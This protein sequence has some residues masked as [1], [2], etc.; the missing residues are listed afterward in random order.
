M[1]PLWEQR[2]NGG[3]AANCTESGSRRSSLQ[4]GSVMYKRNKSEVELNKL[5]SLEAL[6]LPVMFSR[7]TLASASFL[8]V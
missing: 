4:N 8:L 7:F 5:S 3:R 2:N 1:K 6:L